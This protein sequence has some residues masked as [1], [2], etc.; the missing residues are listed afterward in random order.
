MDLLAII[1]RCGISN[2]SVP[3]S[4]FKNKIIIYVAF[5]KLK[6]IRSCSL[7]RKFL[8]SLE[9]KSPPGVFVIA[10]NPMYS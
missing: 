3:I 1:C 4:K 8:E 6:Q 2:P 9:G 10:Q 7:V 5:E